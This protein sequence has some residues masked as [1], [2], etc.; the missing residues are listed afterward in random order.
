MPLSGA[1][2]AE[3]DWRWQAR[4]GLLGPKDGEI[5]STFI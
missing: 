1:E 3:G 2:R 5:A 4:L